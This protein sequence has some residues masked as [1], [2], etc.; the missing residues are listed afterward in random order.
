M[1][2]NSFLQKFSNDLRCLDL[3]GW[4]LHIHRTKVFSD[5]RLHSFQF[6]EVSPFLQLPWVNSESM[7]VLRNEKQAETLYYKRKNRDRDWKGTEVRWPTMARHICN[8]AG[9]L[10]VSERSAVHPWGSIVIFFAGERWHA[11]K[12][13]KGSTI[14]NIYESNKN[15][16]TITSTVSS[17][18][19]VLAN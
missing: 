6:T 16:W 3:Y 10:L 12:P 18:Y 4:R 1:N 9:N 17:L 13:A 15:S 11:G 5:C 14:I 7:P 8:W 2:L 19:F